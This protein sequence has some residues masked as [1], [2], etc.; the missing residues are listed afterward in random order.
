VLYL[1]QSYY[2][3]INL[4]AGWLP[5]LATAV[6][7]FTIGINISKDAVFFSENLN[8][9]GVITPAE[10][11][12]LF[13]VS[14]LFLTRAGNLIAAAVGCYCVERA[15]LGSPG[16][17]PNAMTLIAGSTT[18]VAILGDKMP[19]LSSIRA[20]QSAHRLREVLIL[21]LS[22]VAITSICAALLNVGNLTLWLSRHYHIHMTRPVAV[23]SLAAFLFA[24][25]SVAIGMT[26]HFVLPA[27]AA[28]TV[29][30]LAFISNLA[31]YLLV[32]P[33]AAAL[34]LSLAVADRR[35]VF[36]LRKT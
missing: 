7:V 2:R 19:W 21:I 30:I 33:F 8:L 3:G 26:R 22:F 34:A 36:A 20:N 24:W 15:V 16:A 1:Q 10:L 27:L 9:R 5:I 17:V 4:W 35:L 32:V 13:V 11:L 12:L 14:P 6:F 31:P 29:F 18:T 25:V 28:P 23:F